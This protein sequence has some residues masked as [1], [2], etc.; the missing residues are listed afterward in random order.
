MILRNLSFYDVYNILQMF[1]VSNV[2]RTMRSMS[3]SHIIL[4]S[5]IW[6]DRDVNYIIIVV[7][8]TS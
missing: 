3:M 8:T 6:K 5:D 4:I 7:Y 2:S 1:D